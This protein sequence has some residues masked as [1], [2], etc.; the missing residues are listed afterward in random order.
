[1][2]RLTTHFLPRDLQTA[3][4]PL[5][6]SYIIMTLDKHIG[7]GVGSDTVIVVAIFLQTMNSTREEIS[8][9]GISTE[10][11]CGP[12]GEKRKNSNGLSA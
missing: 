1:M 9:H 6:L 11:K 12:E 8:L 4:C 3:G 7:I 2:R 10:R 5:Y